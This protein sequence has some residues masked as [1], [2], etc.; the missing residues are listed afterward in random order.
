M[1][2]GATALAADDTTA[3]WFRKDGGSLYRVTSDNIQTLLPE[4]AAIPKTQA[5]LAL[6]LW[7]TAGQPEPA[8]VPAF[9][10]V[11]DAAAKAAQ[12]CTEQGYLS[13][14]FKPEKRVTQYCVIDCWNKAFPAA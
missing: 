14:E 13:G 10:D 4:G 12:W 8:A 7:N 5:Q 1:Q 9:A 3:I 6:L 2:E 11:D